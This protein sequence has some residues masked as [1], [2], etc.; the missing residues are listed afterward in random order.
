[1]ALKEPL[2]YLS[3]SGYLLEIENRNEVAYI[4]FLF[5]TSDYPENNSF[6]KSIIPSLRTDLIWGRNSQR[7]FNTDCFPPGILSCTKK[8]KSLT[9]PFGFLTTVGVYK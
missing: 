9:I 7:Q 5:E 6:R 8:S 3:T 1:M 4:N 2:R